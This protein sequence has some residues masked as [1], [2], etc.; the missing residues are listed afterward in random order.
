L[1]LSSDVS[2]LYCQDAERN[3]THQPLDVMCMNDSTQGI[4]VLGQIFEKGTFWRKKGFKLRYH[5]L[6]SI[7]L[8]I[9]WKNQ[10]ISFISLKRA[11]VFKRQQGQ[12][13]LRFWRPWLCPRPKG[14]G[15]L[16]QEEGVLGQLTQ[17]YTPL[18]MPWFDHI[19]DEINISKSIIVPISRNL[20]TSLDLLFIYFCKLWYSTLQCSFF[21]IPLLIE[22][23]AIYANLLLRF[24][25]VY[26]YGFT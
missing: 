7:W 24:F 18:K 2:E 21:F 4:P 20:R 6:F 10:N 25:L 19:F 5:W 14:L 26:L 17:Y 22:L 12:L 16:W 1:W 13:P 23:Y 9:S 3:V 15:L 8:K 11:P